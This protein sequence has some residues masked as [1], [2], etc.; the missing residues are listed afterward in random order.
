LTPRGMLREP[1]EALKRADLIALTHVDQCSPGA[2]ERIIDRLRKIAGPIPVVKTVHKPVCLE[3]QQG[4]RLNVHG[5]EGKGVFAF[6]AIGNPMS[7]RK[8]IENL[9][10]K[11][12]GFRTFPDHHAYSLNDLKKLDEESQRLMPDAIITTQK[13]KVKI[14]NDAVAWSFPLWTLKM[15]IRILEGCGILERKIDAVFN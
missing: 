6:C 9:G 7:L 14:K 1:L 3:T 12:L 8:S 10:A 4:S 2:V 5:L 15:E 13:D 11:V